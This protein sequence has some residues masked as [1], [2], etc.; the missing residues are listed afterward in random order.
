MVEATDELANPPDRVT[1]HALE[2]GTI[3][4]D[5][6]PPVFRALDLKGRRLTGEV[7][8]GVGP[9]SRI[10]VS[11]AGSDEW[12]PIFPRDGIFDQPAEAF[13]T[14]ISSVVPP[15]AAI[16]AVRAYDTAGNMVSRD[17]EAR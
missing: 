6:T 4:V 1:R 9:I 10:E 5:N 7:V 14:D 8:D 11:V 13:D 17:I 12:R 3:L 2:S 16:V 15:G